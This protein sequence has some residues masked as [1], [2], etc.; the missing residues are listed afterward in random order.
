MAE[1]GMSADSLSSTQVAHPIVDAQY[2]ILRELGRGGTAVVYLARERTTGAEVA[3]KL[4]RS[5]YIEDEEAVARFAR[6]ARLVAQL[7]HPNIVPVRAVLDR[8]A[9]RPEIEHRAH[10][11]D[12]RMI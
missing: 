6:E 11:H 8:D 9:G 7:D 3:I 12:V 1:P 2:E 4:I 5:K 10:W